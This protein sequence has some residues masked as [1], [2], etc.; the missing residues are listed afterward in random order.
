M[1]EQL[2]TLIITIWDSNLS[3]DD[4]DLVMNKLNKLVFDD[5]LRLDQQSK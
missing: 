4:E 2:Q 5:D 3:S 1:E